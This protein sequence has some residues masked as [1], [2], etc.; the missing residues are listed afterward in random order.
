MEGTHTCKTKSRRWCYGCLWSSFQPAHIVA[1]KKYPIIDY[2]YPG[3]QGGSVG[4]WAFTASKGD[5]NALAELGAY[6]LVL[7]GTSNPYRSKSF[8]DMSYGNMSINTLPD[9]IAAI[10]QLA[11]TYPIDVDKVGIW[12]I[13]AEALQ[14]LQLC[15]DIQISLKWGSQNRVIM[16]TVTMKMTGVKGITDL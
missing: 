7:E 13:Q 5:N 1:G 16:I 9:Q 2:I 12:G 8:H 3:P 10:K 14:L 11:A 4:S 6:V 15:S